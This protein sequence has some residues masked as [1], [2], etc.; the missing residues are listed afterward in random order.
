MGKILKNMGG[1]QCFQ[2]RRLIFCKTLRKHDVAPNVSQTSISYE[3]TE[4]M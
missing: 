4:T 1:E 2:R 3:L